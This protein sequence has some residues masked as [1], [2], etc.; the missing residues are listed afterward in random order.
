VQRQGGARI[1]RDGE[2][3]AAY[4]RYYLAATPYAGRRHDVLAAVYAELRS[5]GAWMKGHPGEAAKWYAPLIGVDEATAE[6]ANA[7]RSYAVQTM[8]AAGL[9]EQQRIADAFVA[10]GVIPRAVTVADAPVWRP[11]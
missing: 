10:A 8:D 11:A 2:G 7:R 1:V 3:L 9:A 5:A 4:R 6:A